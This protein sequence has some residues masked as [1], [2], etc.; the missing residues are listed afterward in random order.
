MSQKNKEEGVDLK[1]TLNGY[2]GAAQRISLLAEVWLR[3]PGTTGTR[4]FSG[5]FILTYLAL[6]VGAAFTSSPTLYQFWMATGAWWCMH[7]FAQF[8]R[9][10]KGLPMPH[11]QFVGQSLLS[12]MGGNMVAVR[13]WEP[14]LTFGTGWYMLKN[15]IEYSGGVMALAVSLLI[16]GS[17]TAAAEN[18]QITAAKDARWDGAWMAEEMRK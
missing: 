16:S 3:A 13:L 6:F 1:R 12:F 15:G 11:S 2:I 18:A 7:K 10:R 8:S 5:Q 17:Y 9:K 4:Y 14:L